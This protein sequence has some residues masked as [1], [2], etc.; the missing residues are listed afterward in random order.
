MG[1]LEPEINNS[2][3]LYIEYESF[4][5]PP[6]VLRYDIYSNSAE[7]VHKSDSLDDG[8]YVL[9]QRFAVSEDKTE[10]PMFIM[11]KKGI[12]LDGST[13]ALMYG[14]GGYGLNMPPTYENKV[15]GLPVH[16]WVD[17]GNIYVNCN[18]RGG[19]EYGTKW[20]AQ[21]RALKKKN[22]FNDFI[23]CAKWLINNNYTCT[24]KLAACGVSNGGLLMSAMFTM[25]PD[26][27]GAIIA[28]VPHTDLIRF[29][30]DDTGPMYIN[31]YGDP[32]NQEYFEYLL[33]YSPYH[34]V[35]D[36]EKYPSMLI[37][38]GEKDNNVPPY[39]SK[40][41]AALIQEKSAG[42]NP[43]LLRVLKDGS[44]DRGTGKEF[45]K[46]ISEFILFLYNELSIEDEF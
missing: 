5:Y 39:H 2:S 7:V 34:N 38:T 21:G 20:H 41:F 16:E 29:K 11:Y 45:Y 9:E 28:S 30:N 8:D 14:Y 12:N 22:A 13:P 10:V 25:R 40:K 26:L 15:I 3:Y 43:V 6:S 37:Q 44:H 46:T 27:F 4:F 42:D 33:S 31:E 36:K 19:K 1:M 17:R 18:I 32:D 24:K 35:R 23:A